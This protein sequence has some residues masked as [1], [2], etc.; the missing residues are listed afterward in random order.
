[1]AQPQR[2]N[3][4]GSLTHRQRSMLEEFKVS[5]LQWR[6]GEQKAG[7]ELEFQLLHVYVSHVQLATESIAPG[8]ELVMLS[9][10]KYSTFL[11]EEDRSLEAKIKPTVAFLF[12]CNAQG[13]SV[14]VK[15]VGFMPYLF[16]ELDPSKSLSAQRDHLVR[17]CLHAVRLSAEHCIQ[18]T[19]MWRYRAYGWNSKP[20]EPRER[21][22]FPFLKLQC[23]NEVIRKL[24]YYFLERKKFNVSEHTIVPST[25]LMAHLN[26]RASAWMSVSTYTRCPLDARQSYCAIECEAP[27]TA[28][29]PLY[30]EAIAPLLLCAFDLECNSNTGDFPDPSLDEV[31]Y[32]GLTFWRHGHPSHEPVGRIM[33][34]LG[35]C[36]HV[37][38][39]LVLCFEKELE[40]LQAFRDIIV[41]YTDPDV[42]TG[43]NISGFDCAYLD[44]RL[45]TLCG[46]VAYQRTR[47]SFSSRLIGLHEPMRKY[48]KT[49]AAMGENEITEF[50]MTGR[51]VMDMYMYIKV[52][53]KLSSY[54]LDDVSQLYVPQCT[55]KVTLCKPMWSTFVVDELLH[56]LSQ[57]ARYQEREQVAA[58]IQ[59]LQQK[60]EEAY[61]SWDVLK[62]RDQGAALAFS[63]SD[64]EK[65]EPLEAQWAAV[66]GGLVLQL[67]NALNEWND[68]L[69]KAKS[70]VLE[71]SEAVANAVAKC[72]TA[73]GDN[74]YKKMFAMYKLTDDDRANIAYYCAVDCDLTLYLM[75]KLAVV[76][77]VVLMSR[78]T[79]TLLADISS[80]GQQ[81]KVYNQIYR[82]CQE[83]NFVMNMRS[84]GW[85]F[86]AEFQGA[87][88]LPP[89]PN[90]YE[91]PIATLD[92]A[93][94][95]P[96]IMQAHNLCFSTVILD[97]EEKSNAMIS[98]STYEIGPQR[99]TFVNSET[100]KG[101][102]PSILQHLLTARKQAKKDMEA[103]TDPFEQQI[104]NSRQLALKI[105]ANSMYGFTGV[106]NN[107]MY[108]CLWVANTV[109]LTGRKMID[110]TK[111][112]V[113]A[114]YP[115]V[116]VVYGDT[117]SVMCRFHRSSPLLEEV[118]T[119]A[120]LMPRIFQVAEDMSR[121]AS[122]L[123]KAPNK[124]EFEKVYY[125]YLLIGKKNYVGMK[126]EG[127]PTKAPKMDAKGIEIVRRDKIAILR[128][129]LKDILYLCLQQRAY[130]E[131]FA[132]LEGMIHKF[133]TGSL[134]VEDVVTSKSLKS[135][136][137]SDKQPQ[138]IVVRKMIKRKAFGVPRVGDR[139]PFVIIENASEPNM[140]LRAEH[141]EYAKRNGLKLDRLYYLGLVETALLRVLQY[142]PFPVPLQTLF[143]QARAEL[144]RRVLNIVNVNR[145]L[146]LGDAPIVLPTKRKSEEVQQQKEK[147]PTGM[148]TLTTLTGVPVSAPV[149]KTA[150]KSKKAAVSNGCLLQYMKK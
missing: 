95:Y 39:T 132:M 142:F 35:T 26:V 3:V 116:Q 90:F 6:D 24:V 112:F 107:G 50:I 140:S 15:T 143:H 65:A 38:D 17:E 99:A 44:N 57:E 108:S 129:T 119:E 71:Q 28:F 48:N 62:S 34:V 109:T 33:L 97:E 125:P 131:A 138:L 81:I 79:H 1:M 147:Q 85:D 121:R 42:L 22:L 98:T 69:L 134:T 66:F 25:Q 78:V 36:S 70:S 61:A 2:P 100:T 55:G 145:F 16:V 18:G 137:K 67:L 150:K 54:N 126:Y 113:E 146:V 94:L 51:M 118:K 31:I 124:L 83:H 105:S 59:Q 133:V 114:N 115:G 136:Y 82:F 93:S 5:T 4:H 73:C 141:P 8:S 20:D 87:T 11:K 149:K 49:S 53:K 111:N 12:G 104:Y 45:K 46:V 127:S 52:N 32:I 122:A 117:D 89:T 77:D 103:A 19:V 7:G 120:E 43:Y 40:M 58:V 41:Y 29:V 37:P 135:A 72:L 128:N 47:F 123:F 139:V 92:F 14:C 68:E 56:G 101:I 76:P 148:A 106:A 60:L 80:R 91:D 23:Q 13:Q 30:S 88:V 10:D 74:N 144:S 84:S 86:N 110:A 9:P 75:H 102:L 130:G 96:S 64:R 21:Q 63:L 27:L